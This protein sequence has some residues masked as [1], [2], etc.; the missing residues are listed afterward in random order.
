MKWEKCRRDN[1]L[2]RF[3]ILCLAHP[4]VWSNAAKKTPLIWDRILS[5]NER[6][7]CWLELKDPPGQRFGLYAIE[8]LKKPDHV[9]LKV[10]SEVDIEEDYPS[11]ERLLQEEGVISSDA[12]IP[13]PTPKAH[14]T[15]LFTNIA[16]GVCY[17]Y[18]PGVTT[19]EETLGMIFKK[20]ETDTGLPMRDPKVFQWKEEH[21][22]TLTA[23]ARDRGFVPYKSTADLDDVHV[24]AEGN[25]ASQNSKWLAVDQ[26]L[27][28]DW[29]VLAFQ[30]SRADG[31]FVFGMARRFKKSFSLPLTGKISAD[32]ILEN[33]LTLRTMIENSLG[34]DLRAYCFPQT[35]LHGFASMQS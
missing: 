30:Q 34:C 28:G 33:M 15:S 3:S 32:E 26:A 29:N 17:A 6:S 9:L 5:L 35:T 20:I 19:S 27:L 4:A 24:T 7:N 21:A 2:A 23:L 18:S 13:R 16:E 12:H 8:K 25:L 11:L 31:I 1:D 14:G 10:V 22:V